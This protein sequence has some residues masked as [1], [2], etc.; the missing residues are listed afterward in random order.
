LYV[1]KSVSAISYKIQVTCWNCILIQPQSNHFAINATNENQ[2]LTC[3]LCRKLTCEATISVER[4]VRFDENAP[5][6]ESLD[7]AAQVLCSACDQK[8]KFCSQCGGGS[9]RSGKYRPKEL[10]APKKATCAL[11]HTRLGEQVND[12]E[13]LDVTY[14]L[15]NQQQLDLLSEMK[16]MQREYILEHNASAEVLLIRAT[17]LFSQ[18]NFCGLYI[19]DGV[20]RLAFKNSPRYFTFCSGSKC[21]IGVLF[22]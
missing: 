22:A 4:N 17:F 1:P 3:L 7:H 19:D 16:L 8:Y 13:L 10:F 18:L 20:A 5:G 9:L 2:K 12:F 15:S 14:G 21:A 11:S 6:H